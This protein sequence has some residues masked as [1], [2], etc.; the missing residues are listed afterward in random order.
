VPSLRFSDVHQSDSERL[1]S[2]ARRAAQGWQARFG[3]VLD[4]RLH[5]LVR[6]RAMF[7]AS[8][9]NVEPT[10]DEISVDAMTMLRNLQNKT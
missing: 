6:E 9:I 8:Q 4:F 2:V 5:L 10:H 1:D 3:S 7:L